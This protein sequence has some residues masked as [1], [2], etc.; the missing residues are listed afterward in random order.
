MS[1]TSF[2]FKLIHHFVM[3]SII[4]V[5][6]R[7]TIR[8]FVLTFIWW[9]PFISQEHHTR[10]SKP[11]LSSW[12]LQCK[13]PSVSVFLLFLDPLLCI[14]SCLS[15][16]R[17]ALPLSVWRPCLPSLGWMLRGCMREGGCG[18][19]QGCMLAG[20]ESRMSW[21]DAAQ[22]PAECW[23]HVVNYTVIWA[24]GCQKK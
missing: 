15:S 12:P 14:V 18:C 7:V 21:R 3:S 16:A 8:V 22:L 5:E 13:K 6:L 17:T 4:K 23:H 11:R 10:P 20:E 9:F 2:S 1:F 24:R 19:I